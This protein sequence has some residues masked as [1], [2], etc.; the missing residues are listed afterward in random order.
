MPDE[1][2]EQ[3]RKIRTKETAWC[4][5]VILLTGVCCAVMVAAVSSPFFGHDDITVLLLAAVSMLIIFLFVV[6]VGRHWYRLKMKKDATVCLVE[7]RYAVHDVY[8]RLVEKCAVGGIEQFLG[9]PGLSKVRLASI[10]LRGGDLIFT[11]IGRRN[12]HYVNFLFARTGFSIYAE[13]EEE[14]EEAIRQIRSSSSVIRR[15]AH[16]FVY[17]MQR[18]QG[19]YLDKNYDAEKETFI[20]YPG[21][22]SL[23]ELSDM[24]RTEMDEEIGRCPKSEDRQTRPL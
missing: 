5:A 16:I 6:P 18:K 11:A 4:V 7:N 1:L 3:L 2:T 24:I 23:A 12:G 17:R 22:N 9:G 13:T 14:Q 19:I 21:S 20:G 15:R 8:Y 10:L